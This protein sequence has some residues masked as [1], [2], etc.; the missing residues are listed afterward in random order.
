MAIILPR[1]TALALWRW[2][3]AV[4]KGKKMSIKIKPTA[5]PPSN[6]HRIMDGTMKVKAGMDKRPHT[7]WRNLKKNKHHGDLLKKACKLLMFII[8]AEMQRAFTRWSCR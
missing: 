5:A 1:F 2:R 3:E 4:S 7:A 8:R 6:L